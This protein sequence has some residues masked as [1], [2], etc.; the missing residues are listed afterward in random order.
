[1]PSFPLLL[2]PPPGRVS[3]YFCV[4]SSEVPRGRAVAEGVDG[5]RAQVARSGEGVEGVAAFQGTT[6]ALFPVMVVVVVVV[7][8]LKKGERELR[9]RCF[10]KFDYGSMLRGVFFKAS[11]RGAL[12]SYHILALPSLRTAAFLGSRLFGRS[13]VCFPVRPRLC[14]IYIDLTT[15]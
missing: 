14:V 2:I 5:R 15:P 9:A 13:L 12:Q 3:P 10:P 8:V 6:S 1:M 7:G 4:L 11:F